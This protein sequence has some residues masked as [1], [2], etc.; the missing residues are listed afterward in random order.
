ME[1]I[2]TEYPAYKITDTGEVYSLFKY[3]TSII[4]DE[5]ET[6]TTCIR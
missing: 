1:Q 5:W 2:I 3:K 6:S 4:S